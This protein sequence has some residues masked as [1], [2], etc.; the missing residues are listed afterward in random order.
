MLGQT[1]RK[2][3]PK[4]GSLHYKGQLGF[5]VDLVVALGRVL[6]ADPKERRYLALDGL[7]DMFC[8]G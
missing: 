3:P 6:V 1:K 2:A 4:R 8:Q 7:R 5:A